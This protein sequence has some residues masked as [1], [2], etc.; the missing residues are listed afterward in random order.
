[1]DVAEESG[2]QRSGGGI[3]YSLRILLLAAGVYGDDS[4]HLV[5]IRMA[6]GPWHGVALGLGYGY[7]L[8]CDLNIIFSES[9]GRQELSCAK[10]YILNEIAS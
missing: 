4:L 10:L 6:F 2:Q 9:S 1:V 7:P 3:I 8:L 5:G